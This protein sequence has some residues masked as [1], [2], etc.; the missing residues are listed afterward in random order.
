MTSFIGLPTRQMQCLHS[1]IRLIED[2][3]QSPSLDEIAAQMV[4][5]TGSK[6][7]Q[8]QVHKLVDELVSKGRLHR[9]PKKHRSITVVEKKDETLFQ[10]TIRP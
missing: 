9:E 7:T 6:I 8:Q 10:K 2:T 3:G 1:I 4:L 5:Y